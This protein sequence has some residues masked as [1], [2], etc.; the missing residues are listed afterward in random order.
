MFSK[1]LHPTIERLFIQV[2]SIL[3][4]KYE[5]LECGGLSKE[6]IKELK[7][8]DS[9]VREIS[10]NVLANAAGMHLFDDKHD[11]FGISSS[12]GKGLRSYLQNKAAEDKKI[13]K[14]KFPF[15]VD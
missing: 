8:K 10:I 14:E 15:L 6:N 2:L 4:E 11:V 9:E 3:Q 5:L 7:E 13:L 12:E 1:K